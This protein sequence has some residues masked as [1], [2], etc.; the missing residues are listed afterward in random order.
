MRVG[1]YR[2][3]RYVIRSKNM[4]DLISTAYAVDPDKVLG[5]PNWL[6]VDRFDVLATPPS[7]TTG[8]LVT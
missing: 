6:E 7:A 1:F 8:R 5:G 2:G 3:G 4:A